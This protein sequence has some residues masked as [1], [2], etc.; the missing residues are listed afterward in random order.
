MPVIASKPRGGGTHVA[1]STLPQNV[2]GIKATALW[3]G[4]I[5]AGRCVPGVCSRRRRRSGRRPAVRTRKV[6]G[7]ENREWPDM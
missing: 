2:K 6:T 5:G 7:E 4:A 3:A 1:V